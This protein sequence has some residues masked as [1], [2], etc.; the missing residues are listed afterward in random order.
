LWAQYSRFQ[1]AR[2]RPKCNPLILSVADQSL[3][4]TSANT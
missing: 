3:P 1:T 2:L 4:L